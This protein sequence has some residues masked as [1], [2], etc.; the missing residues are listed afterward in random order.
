MTNK[1]LP[2]NAKLFVCEKCNFECFKQSNYN[3]HILTAKHKRL[4]NANKQMPINIAAYSCDCGKTYKHQ[5]SLCKHKK[6]CSQKNISI[7]VYKNITNDSNDNSSIL[8]LISQNK[9][10]MN[11]LVVQNQEHQKETKQLKDTIQELIPKIGNTTNNTTNNQFNLQV[12]LNEDCKD[13]LNFSEFIDKI[14]VSFEDLE[15]PSRNWIY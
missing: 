14:Q 10:L 8:K 2:E 12:F 5:S 4:I 3:I 11:L 1:L 15:K 13:A 6:K 9:E 7:N